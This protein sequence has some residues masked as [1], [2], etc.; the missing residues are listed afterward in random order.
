[1][2]AELK[3]K[4][5]VV[6]GAASGIG[7]AAALAMAGEGAAV[8]V[9]DVDAAGGKETVR[10]IGEGGGEAAFERVD[11]SDEAQ[12]E[13]MIDAGV[14]RFGG[15]DCAFNNAGIAGPTG[16]FHD[17]PREAW[18]RLLAVNLTGIW[19]C[20][21]H[22]IPHML[23]RG[24]GA[25]VNMSSTF[26]IVGQPELVGYVA[27][28]HGVMGLTRAAALEYVTQGIRVN[29]VCPAMIR[30]PMLEGFLDDSSDVS[31]NTAEEGF[32]IS[33][34]SKRVGEPSEVADVVVWLCSDRASFVTGVP[35]PV[36]GGYL[37][38]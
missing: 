11:V 6:T 16:P 15:L 20:M 24:A 36:D 18:D 3:G 17:Y 34:P 12:V 25:I 30:T 2:A 7:R 13:A 19:L 26:G 5:A 28:K 32:L 22:Q 38:Q 37:A 35:V 10:L 27:T 1:M 31:P 8:I 4:V 23:Q 14:A 29:A 21:K 33:Q 9:A